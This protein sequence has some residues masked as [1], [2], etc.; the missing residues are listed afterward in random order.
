[1]TRATQNLEMT[2]KLVK[3]LYYILMTDISGARSYFASEKRSR[4]E[5]SQNIGIYKESICHLFQ[6]FENL[7]FEIS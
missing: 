4:V 5:G 2:D 3:T 1:M 6:L 7:I